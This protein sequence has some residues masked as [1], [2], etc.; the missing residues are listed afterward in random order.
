MSRLLRGGLRQARVVVPA[1]LAAVILVGVFRVIPITPAYLAPA[2]PTASR[3]D[4]A[5]ALAP[6]RCVVDH[7]G[8]LILA[9]RLTPDLRSGCPFVVDF[10][11]VAIA[12]AGGVQTPEVRRVRAKNVGAALRAIGRQAGAVITDEPGGAF[13]SRTGWRESPGLPAPWHL[14]VPAR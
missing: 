9:D 12:E 5:A 1:A 13:S 4:L 14:F 3:E 2:G 7:S 6:Y 10:S 11:G 8:A